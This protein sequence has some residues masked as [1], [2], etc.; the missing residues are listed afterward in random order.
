MASMQQGLSVRPATANVVTITYTAEDGT[1]AA[2]L[3]NTYVK[4]YIDTSLDLRM[5]RLR[6]SGGFFDARAKE[7][8][9]NLERA[10]EKLSEYQQKSG[11]LVG[12]E[13]LNHESLATC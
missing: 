5:E 13:K 6:Q 8:L 1:K 11:L 12:D 4:A 7:L 2:S 10:Q 3:A 9:V